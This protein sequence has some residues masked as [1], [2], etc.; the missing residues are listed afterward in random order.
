MNAST[1]SIIAF[2]LALL[3]PVL[4]QA[5]GMRVEHAA[6]KLVN[7][8]YQVDAR[9]GFGFDDEVL[10]ALEHGVALTIDVII[11]ISQERDWLWDRTIS[12]DIMKFKLEHHPLSNHYLVT[13]LDNGDRHQLQSQQQA[14]MMLGT[15]TK[16]HLINQD[17]L[18]PGAHYV[19]LIK[20]KLD[21]STLPPPLRPVAYISKQWRLESPWYKWVIR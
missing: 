8:A 13:N 1:N 9:I 19:G 4:A 18:N 10:N 5:Q 12:E 3:L 11:R 15:I 6:S 21:I 14:I 7:G 2:M 17:M 16:H 20:A